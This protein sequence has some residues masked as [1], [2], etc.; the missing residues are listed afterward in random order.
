MLGRA[1]VVWLAFLLLAHGIALSLL[2]TSR[3]GV[4]KSS[5]A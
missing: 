5:R 3:D 4:A 1:L 2:A